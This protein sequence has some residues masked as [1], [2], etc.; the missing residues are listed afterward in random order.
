VSTEPALAS[1]TARRA[2]FALVGFGVVGW[3]DEVHATARRMADTAGASRHSRAAVRAVSAMG[4]HRPKPLRLV[5]ARDPAWT[6]FVGNAC[7]RTIGACSQ[8]SIRDR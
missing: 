7:V 8:K 2:R 5:L 6:S 4:V 1:I 3:L